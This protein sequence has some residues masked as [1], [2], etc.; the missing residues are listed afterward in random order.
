MDG[1]SGLHALN[2]NTFTCLNGLHNFQN[3]LL[4]KIQQFFPQVS[5]LVLQSRHRLKNHPKTI[6]HRRDQW[7]FNLYAYVHARAHIS[8]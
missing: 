8:D 4:V 2:Y 1:Y 3:C 5:A 6:N 7:F